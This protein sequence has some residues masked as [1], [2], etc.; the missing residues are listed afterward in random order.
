MGPSQAQRRANV[1]FE[2]GDR[3]LTAEWV[4]VEM[5]NRHG[6]VSRIVGT[7]NSGMFE[8]S[9]GHGVSGLFLGTELIGG[10]EVFQFQR[11]DDDSRELIFN[12]MD[13]DMATVAGA[14]RDGRYAAV[15]RIIAPDLEGVFKVGNVG[16]EEKLQRIA[17]MHSVSVGDVVLE[18]GLVYWMVDKVGFEL[19]KM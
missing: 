7:E 2:I 9:L 10:Y 12:I 1:K 13:G 14:F 18:A 17:G 5:R 6:V 3:V 11:E 16:P 4:S 15:C 8:V 19:L